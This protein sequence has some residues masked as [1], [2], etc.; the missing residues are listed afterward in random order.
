VVGGGSGTCAVAALVSTCGS[1]C[2]TI[3]SPS[4]RYFGGGLGKAAHTTPPTAAA[5]MIDL[6]TQAIAAPVNERNLH[7]SRERHAPAQSL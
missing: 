6:A 1:C 4:P 7:A 5:A 3:G 2:R